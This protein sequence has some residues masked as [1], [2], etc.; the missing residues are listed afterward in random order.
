MLKLKF[1]LL[2]CFICNAYYS[3]GVLKDKDSLVLPAPKEPLECFLDELFSFPTH[4]DTKQRREVIIGWI[5][6]DNPSTEIIQGRINFLMKNWNNK[7]FRIFDAPKQASEYLENNKHRVLVRLSSTKPGKISVTFKR[8]QKIFHTRYKTS[9]I[10]I[11]FNS[12]L[13]TM[14]QFI[15]II[16]IPNSTSA[17]EYIVSSS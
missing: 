5:K 3:Y 11:I 12:Q 13:L 1:L 10:C 2:S 8:D 15:N 6:A 17:A 14:K 16:S 4:K 7:H 9:G